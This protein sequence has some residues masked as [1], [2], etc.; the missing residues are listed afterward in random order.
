MKF[1]ISIFIA[2]FAKFSYAQQAYEFSG[3]KWSSNIE[4]SETQLRSS[5]YSTVKKGSMFCA[6]IN[7][8]NSIDFQGFG[9]NGSASFENNGLHSISI[10]SASSKDENW[11]RYDKLVE[12]YGEPLPMNFSPGTSALAK[13]IAYQHAKWKSKAG[14]TIYFHNGFIQYNSKDSKN[15]ESNKSIDNVKF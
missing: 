3:L 2:V 12:K 14:D 1:Y 11:K 4:Q 8:C 10:Y 15:N 6:Q 5:G 7:N 13:G 9:I